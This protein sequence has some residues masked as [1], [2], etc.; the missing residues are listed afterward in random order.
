MNAASTGG[1]KAEIFKTRGGVDVFRTIE[2]FSSGDPLEEI[3]TGL[4]THRGA[5][6]ASG[7]EYP[8]RYSRWDIGFVDPPVEL[9]ARGREFAICALNERGMHMIQIFFLGLKDHHQAFPQP[10]ALGQGSHVT[11]ALHELEEWQE[12]GHAETFQKPRP[13]RQGQKKT[14]STLVQAENA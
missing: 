14:D 1:L 13:K 7:Y 5:V 4:D 8:G 2:D 10:G 11:T 12:H 3:L 6:F 9:V